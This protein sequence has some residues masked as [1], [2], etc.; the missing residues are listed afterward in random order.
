MNSLIR[1]CPKHQGISLEYEDYH[2]NGLRLNFEDKLSDNEDMRSSTVFL[3]TTNKV[4]LI[5]TNKEQTCQDR[6]T[7]RHKKVRGA[8]MRASS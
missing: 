3:E 2:H 8:S 6:N 5:G 4:C 7:F 1:S